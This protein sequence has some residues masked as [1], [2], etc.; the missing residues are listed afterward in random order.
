V[1][2]LAGRGPV[3]YCAIERQS[4]HRTVEDLEMKPAPEAL[5][6]AASVKETLA[7][8]LKTEEGHRNYKKRKETIEPAFG[9]IK[10]VLGFRQFLMRSLEK[11]NIEWDLVLNIT[12]R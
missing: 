3:V 8:R 9:I 1:S 7:H 10:S 12:V 11:V 2:K 5:S 4:H 6:A